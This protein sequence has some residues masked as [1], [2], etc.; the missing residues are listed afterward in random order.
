VSALLISIKESGKTGK[1]GKT[2]ETGKPETYPPQNPST[3]IC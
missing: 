2:G 1:A 3:N